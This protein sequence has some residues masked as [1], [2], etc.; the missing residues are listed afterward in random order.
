MNKIIIFILTVPLL[1]SAN[2]IAGMSS[3]CIGEKGYFFTNQREFNPSQ[4]GF[5]SYGAYVDE[6]VF[7]APGAAVCGSASI[8]GS[9]RLLGN[10]IV[11]DEAYISGRVIISGNAVVGGDAVITN[12][13]DNP[14]LIKGWIKILTGKITSG[15][16]DSKKLSNN[17]VSIPK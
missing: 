15:T 5:V 4:G 17:F 3:L 11:R 7:I 13:E 1:F 9:V 2:V 8:E 16:Y 14:I 10:T 12:I 6:V